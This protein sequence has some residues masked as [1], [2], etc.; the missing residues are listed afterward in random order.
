MSCD[1]M[2]ILLRHC[3]QSMFWSLALAG[4]SEAQRWLQSP[5]DKFVQPFAWEEDREPAYEE[6]IAMDFAAL[7]NDPETPFSRSTVFIHS[8]SPLDETQKDAIESAFASPSLG[9]GAQTIEGLRTYTSHL[10][11]FKAED[12]EQ[13]VRTFA[14][15]PGSFTNTVDHVELNFMIRPIGFRESGTIPSDELFHLQ[16]GL[17]NFGQE[18][19]G[20]TGE[21]DADIDAPEG[22]AKTTG[23]H[24]VRVAVLDTGVDLDHPDLDGRLVPSYEWRDFVDRDWIPHDTVGHG[25]HIAARIAANADDGNTDLEKVEGI[26][27]IDWNCK[28]LP[29]RIM[30]DAGGPSALAIEAL[31]Y[32][33]YVRRVKIS[34]N[35]WGASAP[36]ALDPP[37]S[38]ITLRLVID[39][40]AAY[41]QHLFVTAPGNDAHDIDNPAFS[42]YPA[43]HN[44]PNM[45][46][47]TAT[48]NRD[49]KPYFANFGVSRVHLGAPGRDILSADMDGDYVWLSGTSLAAPHVSGAAALVLGWFDPAA[50]VGYKEMK[51]V[52]LAGAR[53]IPALSHRTA[54]GG[55]LNLCLSLEYLEKHFYRNGQRKAVTLPGVPDDDAIVPPNGDDQANPDAPD[56]SRRRERRDARFP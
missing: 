11:L 33:V 52:I 35:S 17:H 15:N 50:R 18:I 43:H 39:V 16:W 31:W 2:T 45:I 47:V 6:A 42:V 3:A 48:D 5:P 10:G 44:R 32:A 13:L 7:Q 27:G 14:A 30:G 34:N 20:R 38:W 36:I 49:K 40:A 26:A 23:D 29:L 22:W 24:E 37:F 41:N 25:T 21:I 9:A 1:V 56:P 51:E 8:V 54:T 12:P 55:V 19:R 4:T 46:T 53:P 28:I